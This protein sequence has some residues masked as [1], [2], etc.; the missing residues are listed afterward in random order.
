MESLLTYIGLGGSV[1]STITTAYFWLVRMNGERPNLR[2]YFHDK[3]LFLG[4]G[5]EQTRQLG[6]KLGFIIANYSTLPNALIGVR[7]A[8]RSR[9]GTWL[10]LEGA[11]FDKQT[12]LPF[13]LP[14][15][16]TVVLRV[17]GNLT[18]P[19]QEALEDGNKALGNYAKEHLAEPFQ[20]RVELRQ[21]R[22][23]T[24][25]HDVAFGA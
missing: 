23:R 9:Q 25:T 16:T 1:F 4:A 20:V 10:P 11:T 6:V 7:L 22:D 5:R 12:P 8:V 2:T 21:I 18:F 24:D 19:Y 13:N 3:E 15:L 14:P 17:Q